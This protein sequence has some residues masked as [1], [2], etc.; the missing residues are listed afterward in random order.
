MQLR[1]R[2]IYQVTIYG[3]AI[4]T[5]LLIF[6]F[7]AG[8]LGHS[9]AMIADAVHS[10][11]DFVSDLVVMLF[12]HLSGKPQDKDHDYGHGKYETLATAVIG[13]GL[14]LVGFL[15]L[16]EGAVKIWD[17]INGE[18]LPSPGL[19][20]FIAALASILLK[21]WAYQFTVR[22]GRQVNSEAVIANAWHHRSDAL[23]SV[24]TGLG[25]GGAILLGK[26]WTILDPLAS[27]IVS[28]LILKE[29][30]ELTRKSMGELLEESLPDDQEKIIEKLVLEEPLVS[31]LHNLR[32][33]R[34][35]NKIV[36]DM[37]LRMPGTISL[38]EA[39]QHTLNIEHRLRE[40]F[41]RDNII[42]IHCEP[43]KP[44]PLTPLPLERGKGVRLA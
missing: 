18:Q 41:G 28:I 24:G 43:Q 17:A 38:N 23:S 6:K 34:I 25:I 42:T 44:H 4:N 26:G 40:H 20:A 15:L 33:R 9:S 12:I 2:K 32:T 7:V 37:H 10:L 19:I 39:H 8:I 35:G 13:I 16:Y 3:A 11:S 22:V 30:Y 36:I 14:G 29:A 5:L 31:D 27:I 21:E 1:Q